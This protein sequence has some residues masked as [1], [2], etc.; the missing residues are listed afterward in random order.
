MKDL[1][2]SLRASNETYNSMK[3]SARAIIRRAEI[4]LLAVI[5]LYK[6]A[7]NLLFVPLMQQLWSLTLRFAPMHY[8]SNNNASDIFS[9]PA[10]ILCIT[11]IAILTAFWALYE[12]SV[13]LHGLDLARKGET[14]RL[15]ALLRTSLADIRH[16][17]LP[18]NW[19]VLVYSAVLIPFTNFF[20]AYNYITQLAVPEYIMGVIR[21]NSRYYLLYLA[22]GAALLFLCVSWVLVLPLFVLER[23]SLWQSVKESFCCIR[24]RVF[25]AFLLLLRWNLSVVLRSLLLTAAVAVPL[26]GIIIAVGLQ[27]TQAMFALSRAALAIEMPFF[28]FLIDCAITMAQCTILAMLHC[29]L[30][31]SLPS[32][33]EPVQSGKHHRSTGRLLLGAS[34]AGATLLTFALAFC[35][36]ALPRDDELLSML[37]GVAPVVTAHRGY[38]AAAPENTLPAFQ[39][40]IDQG[41]EW[42]ELDVQMTS[43]GV[44]VVT[45]DS[46]LKRCTGKNAKVYDLTYA[47]V[48]QLDAGRWFSSR[49]ADTRIPTL[50]QVL[51]LCRGR[52][53]LNVEIKPSAA[54][55]A[56]EAET[57]R[58][59]RE[60]GFD[61]SNCV[62]TSQ[63]YETLHKVKALAPEYPTGYILALG[64]GNY[65]DLPDAD[66][67]SVET[68]F[69]TSGMVNAVHLRGKTVS[70]WTI[71]REKVATHMLE[72]GVDDLITDKPDMVQDLLARNQQVDDSLIDFRDLLNALLH[73][74]QPADSS[75]DAEETITDAVEDPEEFVDAA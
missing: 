39:L 69:I 64:V 75:D 23:K 4:P 56:L 53:G 73:P 71:D 59:L 24:R 8:L 19:L 57:V 41:C 66:F 42:A 36:L 26:Y 43:D 14:I 28:Q 16:A 3:H 5:V 10:I 31:E 46:N 15:P 20:L 44:V 68:T 21:A 9:S 45:H 32:E 7:T 55:P 37:G 33:P 18:Q 52:I 51:Q 63:S 67:F 58:L 62:I 74:E 6:A 70:A 61:S 60:Y 25:R 35:Y 22:A 47:E 49:F 13:L 2:T 17:F 40:A 72:L 34:V 29:R 65:Y 12:F 27:S 38:S 11:L 54:T 30:R 48:A 50:E 1:L